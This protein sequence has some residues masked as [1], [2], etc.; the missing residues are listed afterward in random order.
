MELLKDGAAA[1][2]RSALPGQQ[3]AIEHVFVGRK[4]DGSNNGPATNRI[5]I[6]PLP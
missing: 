6:V 2:L 4:P 3:A 1:R 5:R